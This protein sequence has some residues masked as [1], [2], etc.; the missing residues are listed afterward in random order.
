M[1][2]QLL[3]SIDTGAKTVTLDWTGAFVEDV[4][5]MNFFYAVGTVDLRGT[6]DV[7]EW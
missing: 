1:Q 7:L 5:P 2:S 3:A 4:S 6:W